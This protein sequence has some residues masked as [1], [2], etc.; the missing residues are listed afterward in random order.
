MAQADNPFALPASLPRTFDSVRCYWEGLRRG[1]NEMPFWDDVNLNAL[2]DIS[3]QLML[4]DTFEE[5]QRF[6]INTLGAKITNQYGANPTS[7]F[8]DKIDAK[9]PFEFL[10]AQA[11]ATMESKKPTYL[12]L[13]SSAPEAYSRMLLPMWGNGRIEMLLGV[14]A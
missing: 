3:E 1:G 13:K 9:P 8:I 5:P 12:H 6:R 11:S 10:T 14:V 4:I 2:P 7:Q